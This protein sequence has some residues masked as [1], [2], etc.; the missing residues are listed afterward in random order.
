MSQ[1]QTDSGGNSNPHK[2]GHTCDLHNHPFWS[3][4]LLLL[5]IE[6]KAG[7]QR[8]RNLPKANRADKGMKPGSNILFICQTF[9]KQLLPGRQCGRSWRCSS[10]HTEVPAQGELSFWEGAHLV[11]QANKSRKE[12]MNE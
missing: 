3:D 11:N 7:A 6:R 4:G 10:E 9:I 2:G 1:I 5:F 8:L 12:C